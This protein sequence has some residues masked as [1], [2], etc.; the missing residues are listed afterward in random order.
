[1]YVCDPSFKL[2]AQATNKFVIST[3]LLL[4]GVAACE[5]IPHKA[6]STKCVIGLTKWNVRDQFTS[7]IW[8]FGRPD[9]ADVQ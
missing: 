1:M 6:W 4:P 5:G 8:T 2:E 9:A 7:K 3:P